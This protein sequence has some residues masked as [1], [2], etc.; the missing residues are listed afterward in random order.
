[1]PSYAVNYL[2]KWRNYHLTDQGRHLPATAAP[3]AQPDGTVH[4]LV[5][6]HAADLN[7]QPG[8]QMF[9]AAAR[10]LR[11]LLYD[12][13]QR[14]DTPVHPLR[15]KSYPASCGLMGQGWSFAD[16]VAADDMLFDLDGLAGIAAFDPA[17]LHAQSA[18]N[19]ARLVMTLGGTR[20]REIVNWGSPRNLSLA[21]SGTHLGPTIAGAAATASHGSRLGHGGVQNLVRG[22][23][24]V[25]GASRSVWIEPARAPVLSDA[26]AGQFAEEIIRDDAIFDDALVHLGAMGIVSGVV[27]ELVTDDHYLWRFG[28]SRPSQQ[29]LDDMARGKFG[30]IA[31]SHALSNN[32]IFYEVTIN[33]FDWENAEAI[34]SFYLPAAPPVTEGLPLELA[35]ERDFTASAIRKLGGGTSSPTMNFAQNGMVSIFD[36][37]RAEVQANIASGK[38]DPPMRWGELH[39]DVITGGFPGALWNA[40]FAVPR[41]RLP[42]IVPLICAATQGCLPTF[43][44]TI[45]FVS[46]AAGAL[47]FTRWPETAV[48]EIDGISENAPGGLG[49]LGGEIVKGCRQLRA[50]LDAA[51][52]PYMM[53][54]AKLGDLDAARV[55][56][57]FGH[58]ADASSAIARWRRTRDHLLDTPRLR[59]LFWNEA[60]VRYGLLD[61]PPLPPDPPKLPGE[62]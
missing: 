11:Q 50:A 44:Y 33:P 7:G 49:Q 53:H 36:L 28:F 52:V 57:N 18:L 62:A 37:Y 60:V 12:L 56:G 41:D 24:M 55:A 2:A 14:L 17:D 39:G 42:Q 6:F 43:L 29:W 4:E 31:A 27:I 30:N 47:A 15:R 51:S 25:V 19:P 48:I 8:G 22:M 59:G 10:Q 32:P 26:A 13:D 58:A 38:L 34:H 61:R 3:H 46:N 5:E 1:L 20:L 16:I 54:W 9:A 45:R 40:S 21:T 23:H 35:V